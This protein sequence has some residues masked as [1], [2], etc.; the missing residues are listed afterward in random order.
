MVY[1][2]QF[3]QET[4]I[5]CDGNQGNKDE[6]IQK[7]S[8]LLSNLLMLRNAAES[9]IALFMRCSKLEKETDYRLHLCSPSYAHSFVIHLSF[10]SDVVSHFSTCKVTSAFDNCDMMVI[11][12]L[13][14]DLIIVLSCS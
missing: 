8:N 14:L 2:K 4:Q 12:R 6:H 7:P 5:F 9:L 1:Y 3:L 13:Q 10:Y 11:L